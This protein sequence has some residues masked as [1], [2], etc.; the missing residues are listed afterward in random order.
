MCIGL[1]VAQFARRYPHADAMYEYAGRTAG[2][3]TGFMVGWI[4]FV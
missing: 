3:F 4:Y 1:V 2:P